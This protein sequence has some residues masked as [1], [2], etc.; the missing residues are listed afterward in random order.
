MNVG[1]RHLFLFSRCCWWPSVPH[2]DNPRLLCQVL[3]AYSCSFL[4]NHLWLMGV[5]L[6]TGQCIPFPQWGQIMAIGS[7]AGVPR[8]Q[9]P[10]G[11]NSSIQFML[12]SIAWDQAYAGPAAL[13]CLLSSSPCFLLFPSTESFS[14]SN[15]F[16]AS[17]ERE[18]QSQMPPFRDPR[19]NSFNAFVFQM[20]TWCL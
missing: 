10:A 13:T 7:P 8:G 11:I 4:E 1:H 20:T 12:Q 17:A 16:S 6:S 14:S 5:I 19:F 9:P 3:I 15:L 18:T 2:S